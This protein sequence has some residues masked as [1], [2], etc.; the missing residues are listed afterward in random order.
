MPT[1]R[2]ARDLNAL[3]VM[4]PHARDEARAY[5]TTIPRRDAWPARWDPVY[6]KEQLSGQRFN[7]RGGL[8][9][10][11]TSRRAARDAFTIAQLRAGGAILIGLTNMPPMANGGMQRGVYGQAE[12]PYNGDYLTS[13]FGSGSSNGSGRRP[14]VSPH[15][16]SARR[17]GRAGGRR[18][19]T[20]LCARTAIARG[21][22]GAGNWPPVPTMDVVVPHTWTM[23]DMFEVLDVIVADDPD[24]RGDFWRVQPWVQ[25]PRR[26]RCGPSPT[27]RW[28]QPT[29]PRHGRRWRGSGL[30]CRGCM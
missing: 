6:G 10:V 16:G 21:D 30:A 17:R 18:R 25:V 20:T 26:R 22:L 19:R 14:R 4:N 28:R 11:R 5:R 9:R 1:T 29:P 23:A 2:T 15:S 8:A 7:R 3:V 13:A 24:T 12:S 27:C